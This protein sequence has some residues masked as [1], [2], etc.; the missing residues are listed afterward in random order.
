MVALG[1][2]I[3][4]L[5]F[6][7]LL[8]V[9]ILPFWKECRNLASFSLISLFHVIVILHSTFTYTENVTT[10]CHNSS[11]DNQRYLKEL[12]R[13]WIVYYIKELFTLPSF[14]LTFQIFFR[15]YFPSFWRNSFRDSF[16]AGLLAIYSLSFPSS[17][18]VFLSS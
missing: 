5:T 16:G 4:I 2:T 15:Y 8:R 17:E 18:N 7:K 14:T 11:F 9:S 1:I 3:Y 13:W 6:H 12:R 10:W